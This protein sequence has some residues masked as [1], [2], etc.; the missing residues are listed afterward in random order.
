MS[1]NEKPLRRYNRPESYT[2]IEVV[3]IKS[4]HLESLLE[5]GLGAQGR[6]LHEKVSSVAQYFQEAELKKLR[7][8]ATIRNKIIHEVGYDKLDDRR[9]FL[10][11][12]A[13]LER[14]I[15][16]VIQHRVNM[17]VSAVKGDGCLNVI[18][19]IM[20]VIVAALGGIYWITQ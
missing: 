17:P 6:G 11:N 19:I 3:I 5:T 4:K 20:L 12:C 18:A 8:V 7:Y 14:S 13:A 1:E 2:D 10:Q 15:Q 9:G 16:T